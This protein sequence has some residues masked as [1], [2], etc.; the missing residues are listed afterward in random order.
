MARLTLLIAFL[1]GL[2]V[3][4]NAGPLTSRI[5]TQLSAG[6]DST[7]SSVS[8]DPDGSASASAQALSTGG[9]T[10]AEAFAS[11]EITEMAGVEINK[12]WVEFQKNVSDDATCEEVIAAADV[13]VDSQVAAVAE[14]YSSAFGT[15]TVEGT[16]SGCVNAEASGDATADAFLQVIIDLIVEVN[17]PDEDSKDGAFANAFGN[18]VGAATASA[19]AEAFISGCAAAEDGNSF[20]LAE[21]TSFGR[22]TAVPTISAFAW[23]EAGAACGEQAFSNSEIVGEVMIGGNVTADTA[24]TTIVEG[25]GTADATGGSGADVQEITDENGL[26]EA[27]IAQTEKCRGTFTFCCRT[28][29]D[30]VCHCTSSRNMRLFK[31][32]AVATEGPDKILWVDEEMDQECFCDK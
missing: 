32:N 16:G 26:F 27:R 17:F 15:V 30:D 29:V 8:N 28:S 10:V 1:A 22:A 18:L 21:Q 19:W 9:L 11:T 7:A 25:E 2:L 31:C 12:M 23:A 5:L 13:A 14:V 4:G 6:A 20:I 24:S 3:I